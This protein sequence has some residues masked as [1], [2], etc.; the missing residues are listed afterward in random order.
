MGGDF[1]ILRTISIDGVVNNIP[2]ASV[3]MSD[4]VKGEKVLEYVPDCPGATSKQVPF[5][6]L[7]AWKVFR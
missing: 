7:L 1:I 2:V 4:T 6:F 3:S 5:C